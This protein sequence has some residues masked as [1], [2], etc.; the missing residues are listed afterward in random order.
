MS[1]CG[2]GVIDEGEVCDDGSLVNGTTCGVCAPDCQRVLGALDGIVDAMCGEACDDGNTDNCDSCPNHR[3]WVNGGCGDG[4]VF[5]ACGEAC[6]DGNDVNDDACSNACQVSTYC[7][8]GILGPTEACDDGNDDN[9]DDC[10]NDCEVSQFVCGDGEQCGDEACDSSGYDLNW[11]DA[12]CTL[13]VCGDGYVNAARGEACDDG[14]LSATCTTLCQVSFCGDGFVNAL[15]GE[16][17]DTA[18]DGYACDADCT[19]R[20]CGDGYVN[21]LEACDDGDAD[22]CTL[23]CNASCTGTPEANACGDGVARC[24]EVCDDGDAN[25]TY[26]G[27]LA[28]CTGPGPACGDGVVQTAFGEGCDDGNTA[29]GDGCRG[30]CSGLEVC[31]DGVLDVDEVC[32]DGQT[33]ACVG[34]CREDCSGLYPARIVDGQL[35]DCEVCEDDSPAGVDLGCSASQPNCNGGLACSSDIC[36]DGDIGP[37]EVCEPAMFCTDQVTPCTLP[38]GASCPSGHECIPEYPVEGTCLPT[39]Q[40]VQTCGNGVIEGSEQCDDGN[41]IDTDACNNSCF[42]T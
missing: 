2:N 23:G 6:D 42:P 31:G 16:E 27:C 13:P 26:G 30:D 18:G 22:D 33:G 1:T 10:T 37:T 5:A 21:A 24:G 20:V 29:S 40:G 7:G 8:D 9:C 32:D 36:G 28:D 25:G 19:F 39:C 3:L 15:A 4:L 14:G 11:C 34:P 35:E 12:D 38:D 17:C 41:G